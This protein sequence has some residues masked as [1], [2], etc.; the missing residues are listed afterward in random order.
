MGLPKAVG[1][2][3]TLDKLNVLPLKDLTQAGP[4]VVWS[5]LLLSPAPELAE[6]LGLSWLRGAGQGQVGRGL[7]LSWCQRYGPG[8]DPVL[9]PASVQQGCHL[10]IAPSLL[11]S[12]F[13]NSMDLRGPQRGKNGGACCFTKVFIL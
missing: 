3:S 11:K 4:E 5:P 2:H 10:P 12:F 6:T 9:P 8:E 7:W 13:L 1:I